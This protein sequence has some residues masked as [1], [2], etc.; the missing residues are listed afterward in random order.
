VEDKRIAEFTPRIV[1]R[2]ST[3]MNG[4]FALW[5]EA[6]FPRRTDLLARFQRMEAWPL[7]KALYSAWK[8]EAARW[9]PGVEYDWVDNW[10]Q[11]LRLSGWY[12][13]LDGNPADSA[14][15]RG[16]A[17]SSSQSQESA[18]AMLNSPAVFY[19]L[20]ALEWLDRETTA[21]AREVGTEIALLGTK[22]FDLDS[23]ERKYEL[24]SMPD[25]R[26]SGLEMVSWMYVLLKAVDPTIDPEIDL[27][28]AYMT[29]L[30]LH[31]RRAK[32]DT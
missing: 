3:A 22:G 1:Y 32:G 5:F 27:S 19:M 2:A 21:R 15:N 13:W 30:Q 23:A 18:R 7:A 24:R 6:T 4:A 26:Y 9:A 16:E 25:Q 20:A 17:G 10:A 8:A 12:E 14:Q 31:D 28:S 29:A 11:Q